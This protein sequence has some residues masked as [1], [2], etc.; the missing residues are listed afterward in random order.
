M[1]KPPP[2]S[3]S[4][5]F[6]L[7]RAGK[8]VW[9]ALIS[10]FGFWT[11][12]RDA[13]LRD[14]WQ[15]FMSFFTFFV[16]DKS[17]FPA[18]S[19]INFGKNSNW[20]R[21]NVGGKVFQTTKDTLT[22]HPDTLLARLVNGELSSDKDETGA[23]LIDR[24]YEHFD[25]I[26]NYLRT[27]VLNFDRSENATKEL[28]CEADFYGLQALIEEINKPVRSNHTEAITLC[29]NHDEEDVSGINA[30]GT[31][32]FSEPQD[33]Y[34]VLQAL[35]DRTQLQ[36]KLVSTRQHDIDDLTHESLL[37]IQT[38]LRGF[39][40]VQES[41]GTDYYGFRKCWQ[42]VLQPT[43][44]RTEAITICKKSKMSKLWVS[45][46]SPQ[47]T[48]IFSEPQDDYEVLQAL[49]DRTQY[50]LVFANKGRYSFTYDGKMEFETVLRGFGFVQESNNVSRYGHYREENRWKIEC[51]KYVRTVSK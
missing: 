48:V 41:F 8:A 28:L 11:P 5:I 42:F 23:I 37:E 9:H 18:M 45:Q 49:R 14:I 16:Q 17:S 43:A 47:S 25:T 6:G 20:V 40:F 50:N 19:E 31:I 13:L 33:D 38:I 35:R 1:R 27:G 3:G 4:P 21:L 46:Y 7:S 34:K 30:S 44:N 36:F 29:T 39:G 24:S 2:E 12:A 26:L 10:N 51:W 32:C 15:H 22:R